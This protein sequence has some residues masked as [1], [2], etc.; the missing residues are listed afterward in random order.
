MSTDQTRGIFQV[1]DVLNNTYK[2]EQVLGRGGTSEVYRARSEISGRVVALK[3]LRLEY[4]RNE[5]FLALMTREEEMREIRHDAVVR[6]YDNQRTDAGL[7]YLVMDY[8]EGPGLDAKI[9]EGGLPA[10]AL[11]I[12]ARRVAE[13][14][15]AAHGKNI[16]HRDLSPDNIILRHGKPADPVIIDF[17]IAKDTNP[18]AETIVGNEFAGK[19]AYAAPEQLNGQTDARVDIYA[20]GALLLAAFRGKPP[21]IG[22]N[23]MEVITRKAQPLDTEGVPEP[24]KSLIDKMTHPDREKRLQTARDV[25]AEI[26]SPTA[27]AVDAAEI[28]F[29]DGDDSDKT[30]IVPRATAA[31]RAPAPD[32]PPPAPAPPRAP[33]QPAKRGG[34][35]GMIGIV[36]V[37]GLAALGAGGYLSGAFGS[38]VAP[39]YPVAD[40]YTLIAARP[41]NQ[42]VQ[43]L[44]NVPSESVRDD[45]RALGEDLGG[46]ADLT[47]SSGDIPATW[48]EDMVQLLGLVSVLPEWR[49]L[50]DGSRVKVTG[51][52][53]DA[54]EQA[55]LSAA[56]SGDSMPA[57]LTGTVDIAYRPPILA[58]ATLAPILQAHSDC[59]PLQL[60][61]PPVVGYAEDSQ[62]LVLGAVAGAS[63][64]IALSD[65][66]TAAIGNRDLVMNVDILNPTLCLISGVLPNAPAGGFG[67]DFRMGRDGASN[68]SGRY[69]VGENPVID[70][71]I[72]AD[73]N[74]GFLFVSAL[75]VS[76][77]VFH[78]LPNLLMQDNRI[79]ALRAGRE[80]PVTIRVAHPLSDAVDGSKL[81]FT[82]DDSTL[83]KTQIVVINAED[84]MFD[85]LRPTTESA[86]GYAAALEDYS[87]RVRSLDTGILITAA[88]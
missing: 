48:G 37:I 20:L 2:I 69:L 30:V 4:S 8:V 12:I 68:P 59:G 44:G 43:I 74:S 79:D 41:E 13:G 11:M 27:S 80:G 84:Q 67:I 9:K 36:A 73:V 35:S 72:P 6:Y 3:A 45:L 32:M 65:A 18:G 63:T 24:L 33:A 77:N 17:G 56:L 23:P 57:G 25:L 26:D 78:L 86:G 88:R 75:D 1:G 10:D 42:P 87:G 66:L 62:V 49:V 76:G 55:R 82:V 64:R 61:D 50:A 38:L 31:A 28:D 34:R 58:A 47:L 21:D 71:V 60:I 52:T 53:A 83:G 40:P 14:L 46:T 15:V 51:S 70:V 5:D 39:S 29:G 19:Y 22:T 16:V 7:V 81:A 85:G 54:D